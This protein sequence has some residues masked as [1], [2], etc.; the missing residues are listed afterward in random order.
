MQASVWEA[1]LNLNQMNRYEWSWLGDERNEDGQHRY[2]PY[3]PIFSA[4]I[5][6]ARHS[7]LRCDRR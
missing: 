5:E 1:T 7:A 4:E 3:G 2:V 6:A